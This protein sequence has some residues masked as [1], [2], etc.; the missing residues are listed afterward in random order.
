MTCRVC[1]AGELLAH[2]ILNWLNL[3]DHAG[4]TLLLGDANETMSARAARARAAGRRWA[5]AFCA[6]LTVGQVIA[7]FGRVRRDHC[8]YAL[9]R[10]ALPNSEELVDLTAWPP[11]IRPRTIIDDVELPG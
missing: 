6:L 7:T 11:R 2:Y 10:S 9:D 8:A 1:R 3:L 4:N 5:A